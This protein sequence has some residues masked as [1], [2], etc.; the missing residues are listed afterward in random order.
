MEARADYRGLDEGMCS[1][2]SKLNLS[3]SEGRMG[4]ALKRSLAQKC[5]EFLLNW[6]WWWRQRAVAAPLGWLWAQPSAD[7]RL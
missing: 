6:F 4:K 5:F 1:E 7:Q 3:R 2:G